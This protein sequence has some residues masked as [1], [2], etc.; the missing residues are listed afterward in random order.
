MGALLGFLLLTFVVL[1]FAANA[2]TFWFLAHTLPNEPDA[3]R[4]HGRLRFDRAAWTARDD[5]VGML[6]DIAQHH[7]LVGTPREAVIELLG[8]PQDST[9]ESMAYDVGCS[10]SFIV[11]F[12]HRGLL[13]RSGVRAPPD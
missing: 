3:C 10:R 1:W 2:F 13:V 4:N 8:Q 12:D 7:L 6:D 11:I 9:P 5:Q